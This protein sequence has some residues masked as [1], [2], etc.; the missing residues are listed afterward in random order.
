M[1][2]PRIPKLIKR[3]IYALLLLILLLFSLSR[4]ELWRGKKQ[5][6]AT[7]AKLAANGL[8]IDWSNAIPTPVPDAQNLALARVLTDCYRT[9]ERG[10]E[11]EDWQ[12]DPVFDEVVSAAANQAQQFYA[13]DQPSIAEDSFGFQVSETELLDV[14]GTS[15]TERLDQLATVMAPY[16]QILA[17]L[18]DACDQRPQS[19]FPGDYTISATAPIPSFKIVRP[20]VQLLTAEAILAL[21]QGNTS[22]A[23]ENCQALNRIAN[24]NPQ[25]PF[26]VNTMVK[27][28][29]LQKYLSEVL[30]YGISHNVFNESQLR[31]IIE[32]CQQNTPVTDLAK[33]FQFEILCN[34]TTIEVFN[35]SPIELSQIIGIN[36][37]P[38]LLGKEQ[39]FPPILHRI[40]WHLSPAEGWNLQ[41]ANRYLD[42][43]NKYD[44]TFDLNKGTVDLKQMTQLSAAFD[45]IKAK[46]A[47]FDSLL[48]ISIPAYQQVTDVSID[49]QRRLDLIEI[50]ATLILT[51][52]QGQT[53][54]DSI[55]SGFESFPTD[56]TNQQ[57]YSYQ[58]TDNGFII[59]STPQSETDSVRADLAIHWSPTQ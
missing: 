39:T 33:S 36:G 12:A 29:V 45:R 6:E 47:F 51:T 14:F 42:W 57:S 37:Y 1:K 8:S 52:K 43:A 27:A 19:Y 20:A 44:A 34:I 5:W 25:T 30:W 13:P 38:L 31:D 4:I 48:L 32:L 49:T 41:M 23:L 24:L 18:R 40:L 10:K 2:K 56:P 9:N 59:R 3:V 26:L 17:E 46:D 50:A 22:L 28:V 58:K 35:N 21:H 16:H 54:P 11:H 53:L 7:K 15:A 55:H